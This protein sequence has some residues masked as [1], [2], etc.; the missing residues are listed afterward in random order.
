QMSID[1]DIAVDNIEDLSDQCCCSICS[2]TFDSAKFTPRSLDCG[3]TFCEGCIYNDKVRV[4]N[5]VKCPLC[6]KDTDVP[7]GKMLPT[8]YLILSMANTLMKSRADPKVIC[9]VCNKKFSPTAVRI[10]VKEGCNM[11]NQLICLNC[12]I[13]DGHGTHVVKYDAKMEKI[14]EELRGKVSKL[15]ENME[16]QKKS[17]I[18][19]TKLLAKMATA[20]ESRFSQVNIPTHIIGQL[21]SLASEQ[22]ADEYMEIVNDLGETLMNGCN[23]LAEVLDSALKTA[24][25]QFDDLFDDEDVDVKMETVG[26]TQ[27]ENVAPAAAN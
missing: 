25:Q 12:A 5:V 7:D 22:E 24:T 26:D 8:N 11:L 9:K 17:V 1:T 14:R 15:S 23:T 10:C 27:K 18:E 4:N 16:V 3:H 13:D 6:Q 21:D 20:L 19:K 2:E